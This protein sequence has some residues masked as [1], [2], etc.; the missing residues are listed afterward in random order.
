M[1]EEKFKALCYDYRLN[2]SE[3]SFNV[4][5]NH[6]NIINNPEKDLEFLKLIKPIADYQNVN[7]VIKHIAFIYMNLKRNIESQ[8][9]FELFLSKSTNDFLVWF[10]LNIVA[11]ERCDY[12]LAYHCICQLKELS[13]NSYFIYRAETNYFLIIGN[14]R[15]A[16]EF[17]YIF[18]N[19]IM[20][21]YDAS[22][23]LEVSIKTDDLY[24]FE[25]I[26]TSKFKNI[27][28]KGNGKR[29]DDK[30]KRMF[31]KSLINL[32]QSSNK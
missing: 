28:F 25:C 7:I 6:L 17:A 10:N 24:L 13:P 32:I 5:I 21:I 29:Y 15:K 31:V 14:I 16:Q 18:C 20:N 22:L 23:I 2:P 1:T 3:D 26:L 4:I 27:L 30:I 9:H 19:Q 12:V 11:C 8:Y